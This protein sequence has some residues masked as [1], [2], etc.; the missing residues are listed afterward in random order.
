MT[1]FV[2]VFHSTWKPRPLSA[3]PRCS[4]SRPA[5]IA[6]TASSP[7]LSAPRQAP[8]VSRAVVWFREG[9]LRL[10][11]HPGLEAACEHTSSALAHLLVCTPRTS[12]ATL[13][14]AAR[15]QVALIK[16]GS[17]LSVRFAHDEADAVVAFLVAFAAQRVHVRKDVESDARAVVD[18]VEQAVL[19]VA[20]VHT[21]VAD[22]REWDALTDSQLVE[23]P[24]RF[25]AFLRWSLRK[26]APVL[27]STGDFEPSRIMPAPGIDTDPPNTIDA[28]STHV[29]RAALLPT[30][31]RQFEDRFQHELELTHAVRVQSDTEAFGEALLLTFLQQAERDE[32]P[33]FARSLGEIFC[34]GVL[35]PRR[36]RQLV[37][38]FERDNGRVLPLFFR[39]A[40]KTVLSVLDAREFSTLLA[41]RDVMTRGTVDGVHEARF[42]RWNGFLIRYVEEGRHSKGAMRGTPPLLLIHGFGASCFHYEKSM[43]MLK[44][45][46]H[47]F[48]IDLIGFG[49]SEKPPTLYSSAVWEAMIWDFVRD[50]I[51]QPVYVAGNS[52]G[53]FF[54]FFCFFCLFF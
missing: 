15:L 31:N 5:A 48:A 3:N 51:A 43:R 21:W 44:E 8:R 12:D 23:V 2:N 41:R 9:D 35:S 49:R 39:D 10:Q 18:R 27:P 46:Y 11:D 24:D 1:A 52:I 13:E 20:H 38:Q 29:R 7:A 53:M 22:L 40:A 14:A 32:L 30:W 37:L 42:W 33:D 4:S 28:V 19:G 25:P 50:V 26:R 6:C 16:R 34:Q 17:H 47:V 54:L 36:M 45:R